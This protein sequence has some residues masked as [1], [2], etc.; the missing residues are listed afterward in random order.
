MIYHQYYTRDRTRYN[1]KEIIAIQ[2]EKIH[3]Y[4]LT[5]HVYQRL[6]RLVTFSTDHRSP[7][8]EKTSVAHA[9]LLLLNLFRFFL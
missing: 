7:T 2:Q 6:Y 4:L 9:N 1:I 8:L 5:Q 3:K